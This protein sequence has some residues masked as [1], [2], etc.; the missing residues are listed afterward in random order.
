MKGGSPASP[1]RRV[2]AA[3]SAAGRLAKF[4]ESE[5]KYRGKQICVIG[6]VSAYNGT[7]EVTA[8]DPSQVKVQ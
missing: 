6:K 5:T 4:G 3:R 1:N 7:P 2:S 8:S